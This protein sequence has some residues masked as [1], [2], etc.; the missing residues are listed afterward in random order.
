VGRAA[1][2]GA[3]RSL[4]SVEVVYASGWMGIDVWGLMCMC[5][6][7]SRWNVESAGGGEM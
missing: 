5:V 7:L 2:V 1:W 6:C 4:V 3:V